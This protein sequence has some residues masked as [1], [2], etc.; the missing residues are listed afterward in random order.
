[1]VY[2]SYVN[3]SLCFFYNL[4]TVLSYPRKNSL[5]E[6]CP[7]TEFF[8]GR[9]FLYSDQKKLRIWTIFTQWLTDKALSLWTLWYFSLKVPAKKS[10][11][12]SKDSV[13]IMKWFSLFWIACLWSKIKLSVQR[14]RLDLIEMYNEIRSI[15]GIWADIIV[16]S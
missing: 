8:L 14:F 3:N 13:G 6:K 11:K 5:R 16:D 9:I 2:L 4:D 15:N 7:N 12:Q 10:T 1:M